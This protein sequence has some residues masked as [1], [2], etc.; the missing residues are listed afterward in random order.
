MRATK[1]IDA[2]VDEVAV[3]KETALSLIKE[4]Y[5][6]SPIELFYADNLEQIES[7]IRQLNDF[8]SKSWL[9][10]A[11]LLYTL[12]YN[13]SLYQQSGLTWSEYT[14]SSRARL[15][16]DQRDITEQLSAARFFIKH[17][18]TLEKVGFNPAGCNAKLAR[19]ELALELSQDLEETV[20]HLTKDTWRQFKAW[21]QGLKP[22]KELPKPTEY[23]RDDIEINDKR[24]YIQGVEAV[25]ISNKIP[26][27]DKE[28]IETYIVQIFEAIQLGYEPAIVPVYD[29]KEARNLF[30][31]RDK[32]RQ[33]K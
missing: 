22:I 12:I 23:K 3:A 2:T 25:K 17:H 4:D 32:Y 15:G 24:I 8:S 16:I 11:I 29:E 26:A 30:N 6:Q 14:A 9:I 18:K 13:K 28:R 19:A 20:E 21:Y 1:S 5:S 33:K 7:G 10:S 27:A 31:L